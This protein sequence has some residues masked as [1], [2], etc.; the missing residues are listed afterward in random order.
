MRALRATVLEQDRVT[1][2]G[3]LFW[4]VAATRRTSRLKLLISLALLGLGLSNLFGET[5]CELFGTGR[6]L[7]S[8]VY[9]NGQF[10]AVGPKGTI[11]SS[12]DGQD[13]QVRESPVS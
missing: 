12:S 3:R 10:V 7:R 13:W 4:T 11:L 5:A 6:D 2:S 1:W 9:G 8:V